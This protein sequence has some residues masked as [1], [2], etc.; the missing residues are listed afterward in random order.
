M[1]IKNICFFLFAS[2]II[3]NHQSLAGTKNSHPVKPKKVFDAHESYV[4]FHFNDNDMDF[5]FAGIVLGA[6]S[7]G[8]AEI[9]EAYRVAA[10]I[11]D[12]DSLSWQT[13]WAKMADLAKARG[14][15]SLSKGH[16]VS[17]RDQFLRASYYYRVSL[18]G[19]MPDDPS[20]VEN[21]RLSREMLKEAG[22]L[23][24]IPLEYFEVPFEGTALPGYFRKA[25]SSNKPLK[26]LIMIGGGETFAEDLYFYIAQAAFDRG[27]NFMT[28]DLPG[29]GLLPLAGKP[30]RHDMNVPLKAVVD[31]ALKRS[32]VDAEKL[33]VYGYSGGGGFVPQTATFDPRIKAIAMNSCVVDAKAL[34]ATM[35][36][37]K[38]TKKEMSTWSTFHLNTVKLINWRWGVAMD[39][40]AGLVDA[41]EGFS[42]DPQKIKIPALIIVGEGEYKSEEVKR[43]QK[44]C[45]DN[46]S[47]PL[48][49]FVITPANEGASNHCVM[50]NR[51]LA[52]QVFFDWADEVLK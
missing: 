38:A 33:I 5:T 34:F 26:T 35:P 6:I 17:A 45:F 19:K 51:K 2:F 47:H 4:R 46:F 13:E 15:N 50:E 7:T 18:M 28:V 36:V 12:G 52:S 22:K 27:Y 14:E 30:F 48:K 8:G 31:Y 41:N 9:G 32:D 10:N 40:P 23:Y 42:F 3:F 39:N 11:K 20:L 43:Q 49:R 1:L 21:T 24:E 29:Q 37:V 16:K 25:A 44:I